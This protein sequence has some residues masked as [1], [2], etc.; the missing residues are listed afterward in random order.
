MIVVAKFFLTIVL[1]G[2]TVC[3][4]F[5][6][7]FDKGIF[8]TLGDR[9][10]IATLGV[11]GRGVGDLW[12]RGN[13]LSDVSMPLLQGVTVPLELFTGGVV[14]SIRFSS[15]VVRAFWYCR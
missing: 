15:E 13:T 6:P 12:H 1:I 2:W 9:R 8:L 3:S 11:Y 5:S 10:W 4:P 14:H 7:I